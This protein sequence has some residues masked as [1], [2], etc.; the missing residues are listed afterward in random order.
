VN[1]PLMCAGVALGM[2]AIERWVPGHRLPKVPHWLARVVALDV[3]QIIVV[4]G[5]GAWLEPVIVAHRLWSAEGLGPV[6]GALLGYLAITFVYYWW[7]RW[8]H[9]VPWLWRT[10]HQLHHSP[11]RLEIL[12]SFYKH[13]LEILSNAVLSTALLYLVMGLTSAQV[14]GTVLIA[15]IAELF[16]HWNVRTPRWVG[17]FIQRPEMHRLHHAAEQHAFNYGDL[18]LWDMLFGTYCNP[19]TSEGACGFGED[20][21]RLAE[22]LAFRDV[23]EPLDHLP[24]ANTYARFCD[25]FTPTL[26]A[27][28]LLTVGTLA[29]AGNTLGSPQLMGLGLMTGAAPMPKVFTTRDGLEAFSSTFTV[30][31]D[32][33]TTCEVRDL[34]PTLYAQ[35]DGPYNRRNVYGAAMAGGPFLASQDTTAPMLDRIAQ[36]A[37]CERDLLRHLGLADTPNEVW[38]W[39]TPRDGATPT[40]LPLAW[41]V[42]CRPQLLAGGPV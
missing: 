4:L 7:H 16:Y 27:A 32:T 18:P 3:V 15:A 40:P 34:D 35:L 21:T 8:R 39:V 29:M 37:F 36:E 11:Q 26:R 1:V 20:E 38:L 42:S 6:G 41:E 25:R 22:M 30:A 12:T 2:M 17:W 9:E 24:H 14:A 28:T 19:H 13:P 31:W 33:G 5:F 10:L 23:T